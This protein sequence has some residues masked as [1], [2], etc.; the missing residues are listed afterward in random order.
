MKKGIQVLAIAVAL[1]A[2]V[3][4]IAVASLFAVEATKTGPTPKQVPQS[5][6]T[7]FEQPKE[8]AQQPKQVFWDLEADHCVVNNVFLSKGS[9]VPSV[10]NSIIAK[11][12]Q[13]VTITCYY[14]VKTIPIYDI[15]EA[16]AIGW[17]KGKTYTICYTDPINKNETRTLPK[18]DWQDVQRWKRS[19]G[20]NNAPKIWTESMA[21]SWTAAAHPDFGDP[22]DKF[23]IHFKVDCLD[24]I[25]EGYQGEGGNSNSFTS[26]VIKITP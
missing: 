22:V 12:G 3:S 15:T 25:K 2:L 11:M 16:D 17:G 14:K 7:K 24:G 19:A 5:P 13:P 18:F 9:C 4:M 20:K 26:C 10:Y 1:S 23:S 21:I 6:Q 8:T